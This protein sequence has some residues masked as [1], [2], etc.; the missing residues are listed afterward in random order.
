MSIISSTHRRQNKL[1]R[2]YS[3]EDEDEPMIE[4]DDDILPEKA[5]EY[6]NFMKQIDIKDIL[7]NDPFKQQYFML[8]E[9]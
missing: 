7:D 9:T 3:Q 5:K 8:D 6:I 1:Q 4:E 2:D